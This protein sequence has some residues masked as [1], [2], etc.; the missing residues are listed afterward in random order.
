M[1][2]DRHGGPRQYRC[3]GPDRW[4]GVHTIRAGDGFLCVV[5]DWF[6][7]VDYIW[8][9]AIPLGGPEGYYSLESITQVDIYCPVNKETRY[10]EASRFI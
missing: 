5:P 7:L 2:F 3:S 8:A 6:L 10:G 4:V 9:G 1:R